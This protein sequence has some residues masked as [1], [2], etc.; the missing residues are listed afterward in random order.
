MTERRYV[1]EVRTDAREGWSYMQEWSTKREANEDAER[2]RN[3]KPGNFNVL[4]VRVRD[5]RQ[6]AA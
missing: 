5:R 6:D 1:I 3:W 4:E 2:W